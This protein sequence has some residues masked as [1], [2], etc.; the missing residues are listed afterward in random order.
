MISNTHYLNYCTQIVAVFAPT[1]YFTWIPTILVGT[2]SPQIWRFPSDQQMSVTL[3]QK[4]VIQVQKYFDAVL[5]TLALYT[6][7]TARC[8]SF[9]S[10]LRNSEAK[11]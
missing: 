7:K 10:E 4:P 6:C 9:E 2:P 11:I 1:Q 3:P 5:S 8:G